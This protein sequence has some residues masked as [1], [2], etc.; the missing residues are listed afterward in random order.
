MSQ[1]RMTLMK[2]ALLLT[3]ATLIVKV[4]SAIY[5]IP[6]QNIVGDRGLYVYQQ[7][8][9][10]Y[11]LA[12]TL[13]VYGFPVM[14][15]RMVAERSVDEH[16]EEIFSFM[17]QTFRVMTYVSFTIGSVIFIFSPFLARLMGDEGLALPI[18][19][20][21]LCYLFLPFVSLGRGY[22]QGNHNMKPTALSQ[23]I[24]QSIRVSF[25]L[26]ATYLLFQK[27]ASIYIIGTAAIAGGVLSFAASSIV[28]GFFLFKQPLFT[29]R[30]KTPTLSKGT[31]QTF[32]IGSFAICIS[33]LLYIFFQFIDAFTF[34]SLLQ[35]QGYSLGDA[36]VLKGIY[37]RSHP[38]IQLGTVVSTALSLAVVPFV[39][40]LYKEQNIK[41]LNT[42]I[43]HAL[44]MSLFT[45]IA[46]SVGLICIIE[47]T[48]T[49]LYENEAGSVVLAILSIAIIGNSMALTTAGLLQGLG[50]IKEPLKYALIGVLV[51]VGLNI[52]FIPL[53]HSNGAAFATILAFFVTGFLQWRALF[54]L[55]HVEFNFMLY[56]KKL[57]MAATVM[58]IILWIYTN[59][60]ETFIEPSRIAAS[61]EALSAVAIG[62]IVYGYVAF[63]QQIIEPNE[64]AL[65]PKG[66][67]IEAYLNKI[68][69][70]R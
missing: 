36:Q 16:K 47:P 12:M 38:L 40:T 33:S 6:L 46:A 68:G 27:G 41:K 65:L 9:P 32:L 21:A 61:F 22:F 24:E 63:R 42:H 51:K 14:I 54:Q 48:N 45:S 35:K 19:V 70:R 1:N 34:V 31:M 44:K 57:L 60:F 37:D 49:M 28:I 53:F 29:Y 69:K 66:K 23:V 13:A 3:F 10:F 11:A 25:I 56:V 20:S 26:G 55:V 2:G 67:K 4:L 39:A 18:K 58:G 15:S 30:K 62:V 50:F 7:A 17:R 59:L 5:R 64:W 43:V 52:L 8:Y